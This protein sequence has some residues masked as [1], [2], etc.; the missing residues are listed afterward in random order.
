MNKNDKSK[1]PMTKKE[2]KEYRK[3]LLTLID[4]T[5]TKP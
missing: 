4:N 5:T 1:S 3:R 2:R